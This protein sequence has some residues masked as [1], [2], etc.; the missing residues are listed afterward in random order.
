MWQAFKPC[1]RQA[2]TLG[3]ATYLLRGKFILLHD[4][5]FMSH[6]RSYCT[7]TG[8]QADVAIDAF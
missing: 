7:M 6:W 5:T 2:E 3:K 1:R 4:I 8:K